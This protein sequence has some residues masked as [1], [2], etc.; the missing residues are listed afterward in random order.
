MRIRAFDQYVEST[1]SQ[2]QHTR[3]ALVLQFTMVPAMMSD[4]DGNHRNGARAGRHQRPAAPY[5]HGRN[6][7]AAHISSAAASQLPAVLLGP[8]RLAHR[9]VDAADC[10][11]LVYLSN[12]KLKISARC[13]VGGRICADDVFIYLGR[14][15]G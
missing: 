1:V 5:A 3:T 8:T 2:H 13:S 12:H 9:H 15:A 10:D 14:H 7:V 11:E 6:H 4:A